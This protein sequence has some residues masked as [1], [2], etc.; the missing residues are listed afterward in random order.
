MTKITSLFCF[1][2]GILLADAGTVIAQAPD[3]PA[4]LQKIAREKDQDKKD[5][6]LEAANYCE[7]GF[8]FRMAGN[9]IKGLEYHQKAL[10]SPEK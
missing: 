7:L 8:G 1:I 9:S 2:A 4:T 10:E 6:M 3:L 5:L